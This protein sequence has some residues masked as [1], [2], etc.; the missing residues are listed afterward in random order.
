MV[1]ELFQQLYTGHTIRIRTA[2]GLTEPVIFARGLP[3]GDLAFPCMFNIYTKV[4]NR[5]L[6]Y[7]NIDYKYSEK[8]T[9]SILAY[10]NDI[11]IL[12]PNHKAR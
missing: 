2:Y 8:H 11:T 10:A 4:I 1:I 3:Q 6:Q 9:I 12:S 7:M 5:V